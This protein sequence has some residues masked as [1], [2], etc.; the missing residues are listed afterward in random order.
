VIVDRYSRFAKVGG[1]MVSLGL[2]GD[3]V[4]KIVDVEAVAVAIPDEKKG[5]KIVLLVDREIPDLKQKLLKINPL[6]IPSQIFV[7]SEI[8]TLGSGKIDFSKA[9]QMAM[10]L[11]K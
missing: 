5:E 11:C 7:I 8:P 10:E 3:E 9:K 6:L 2:V 4:S 1:E